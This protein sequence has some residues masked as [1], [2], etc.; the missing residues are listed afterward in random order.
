MIVGVSTIEIFFSENQSLKDKR[1]VTRKIVGKIRT[2]FNISVME[3]E[4]TNLWQRAHIG[5]AL[6]DVKKDHVDAAIENVHRYVESLYIGK[7]IDTKTEIM[8]M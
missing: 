5:F 8:V 3:V 4:Q 6:V 2:R 7:I 1:Q